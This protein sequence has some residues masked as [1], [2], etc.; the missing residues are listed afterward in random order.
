MR[1]KLIGYLKLTRFNEYVSFVT[2]T[3]LLGVAAAGGELSAR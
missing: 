2:V 1:T 3:T